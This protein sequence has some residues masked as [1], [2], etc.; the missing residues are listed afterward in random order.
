MS[1]DLINVPVHIDRKSSQPLYSQIETDLTEAIASGKLAPGTRLPSVRSLAKMLKVNTVTVVTAYRQ[2]E[3]KGCIWTRTGSGTYVR[4]APPPRIAR[5]I[6]LPRQGINFANAIPTPEIFPVADIK[7]LL[8]LVLDRDGGHAF[9]YQEIQGW[10]PLREAIRQYLAGNGIQTQVENIHIVSGA[11]QGIDL[12]AKVL[13]SHGETIYVDEPGYHAAIASFRS[14]G[15]RIIGIPME[16]DGPDLNVILQQ[17]NTSKP[18]F[19]YTM[20]TFHNPTG[21]SYS[22]HK[23]AALLKLAMQHKFNLVEVDS[24]SELAYN[25]SAGRPLKAMDTLDQVIYI[26]SFSKILMPGLRLGLLVAPASLNQEIGAAKQYSDISSSGLLQRTLELFL[27]E[28]IWHKHIQIMKS[29]Y[30]ARYQEAIQAIARFLPG[31]IE[32]TPPGGGLYLW[33]KLPAGISGDE[34]YNYCLNEDVLITPGSYFSPGRQYNQWIR[35]SFAAASQGEI[36]RGIEII[37]RIL[38]ERTKPLS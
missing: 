31:E 23:K 3:Q 24:M 33:L 4:P 21:R 28:Q 13:V 18:K 19:F 36:A 37:G 30:L 11:Q 7:R 20:P 5:Q 6:F 25:D 32:F 22:D 26:K 27:R 38:A 29:I 8:N 2:L 1:S 9:N 15:A 10:L 17:L 16:P 34:L 35:L 12:A 14:R